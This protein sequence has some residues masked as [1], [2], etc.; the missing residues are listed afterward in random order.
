[1]RLLSIITFGA[2]LV[3]SP[4][5]AATKSPAKAAAPAAAAAEQVPAE[6][7]DSML[8]LK[9]LISAL[10]S[11][12]IAQPLKGGLVGCLYNN[13]LGTITE[14]MNKLIVENPGKVSRSNPNELLG[15]LVAVCGISPEDAAAAAPKPAA[16]STASK[17]VP[18][19]R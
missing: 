3:A 7:R 12:E 13:S 1:M 9:V 11:D 2:A 5:L 16:T 17:P 18:A 4:T 8:Y 10:Q 15:A 14:S 6:V 19:G